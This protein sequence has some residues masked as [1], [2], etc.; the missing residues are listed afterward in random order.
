MTAR[1]RSKGGGGLCAL[2]TLTWLGKCF[3][4]QTYIPFGLQSGGKND[5]DLSTYAA[6]L[7]YNQKSRELV[8]VGGTYGTYFAPGDKSSNASIGMT[9]D[10]FVGILHLPHLETEERNFDSDRLSW[11]RRRQFG[12][13]SVSEFC[14]GIQVGADGNMFVFGNLGNAGLLSDIIPDEDVHR[15]RFGM[16]LE[17]NNTMD[18]EGGVVFHDNAEEYPLAMASDASFQNAYIASIFSEASSSNPE[19]DTLTK[20]RVYRGGEDLATTGYRPPMYGSDFSLRLQRLERVS[21][22]SSATRTSK[23]IGEMT[24]KALEPRWSREYLTSGLRDV[25]V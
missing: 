17:M 3:C 8:V 25:Q 24:A 14:S 16:L 21:S 9:S 2:L 18:L 1:R 12:S 4:T 23:N 22:I 11:L 6:A 20:S 13:D 5:S 7:A 19:M 10:C 15:Q